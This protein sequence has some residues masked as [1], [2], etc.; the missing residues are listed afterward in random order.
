MGIRAGDLDFVFISYDEPNAEAHWH[1]LLAIVPHSKRVQDVKGL[2][3]A[4]RQAAELAETERFFTIDA[5][6]RLDPSFVEH[7]IDHDKINAQRVISWPSRNVVNGLVYGNGGV[8]CWTRRMLREDK[9][10]DEEHVDH[11][12]SFGFIL[13]PRSFSSCHPNTTPLHSFRAGFREGA[14]LTLV[15]GRPASAAR[16]FEDVS[17]TNRQRLRIWCSLGSDADHGLWCI[18]GARMGCAATLL[19]DLDI[20]LLADFD[21]FRSFFDDIVMP[22]FRGTDKTCPLS[23]LS[24]SSSGLQ[25]ASEQLGERLRNELD[26]AVVEIAPDQSEFIKTVYSAGIELGAFDML[27]NLYRSG[28]GLPKDLA[29]AAEQYR[30]GAGLGHSNAMNNLARLHLQGDGVAKDESLAVQLLRQASALGNQFA[31]HQLA[32]MRLRGWLLERDVEA[33]IELLE[34]AAARGFRQADFELGQMFAAEQ[35]EVRALRH[36]MLAG[37]MGSNAASGLVARLTPELA[38]IARAQAAA[39]QRERHRG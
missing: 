17:T 25:Q 14:R 7:V 16:F 13:E 38:A 15:R 12:L 37:E 11:P 5:D 19:Q 39:R 3:S 22:R 26:L 31:P 33:G 9:T 8:K 23:G 27:G 28:E 2:V 1:D 30:I 24:W 32:R 29:K 10:R 18:Y 35:D 20:A 36:F 4:F 34:Q 6:T 21:R